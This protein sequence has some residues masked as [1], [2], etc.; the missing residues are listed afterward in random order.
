MDLKKEALKMDLAKI[1]LDR[2]T[3]NNEAKIRANKQKTDLALEHLHA[4]MVSSQAKKDADAAQKEQVI[5]KKRY[6]FEKRKH[7]STFFGSNM[8]IL[9]FS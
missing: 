9:T 8:V 1:A 4:K 3:M 2:Q 7:Y 6:E 5:E